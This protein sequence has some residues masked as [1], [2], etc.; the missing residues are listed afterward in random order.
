MS[1]ILVLLYWTAKNAEIFACFLAV[2]N[3]PQ[4]VVSQFDSL[5]PPKRR[6]GTCNLAVVF[7]EKHT[8]FRKNNRDHINFATLSSRFE[9]KFQETSQN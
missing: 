6:M 8:T 2:F 4:N 9:N 5:F 7:L 3:V 1:A